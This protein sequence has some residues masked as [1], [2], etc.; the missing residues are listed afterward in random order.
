MYKTLLIHGERPFRLSDSHRY[1]WAFLQVLAWESS[2]MDHFNV[3]HSEKLLN[4]DVSHPRLNLDLPRLR[5]YLAINPKLIAE[6]TY[7]EVLLYKTVSEPGRYLIAGTPDFRPQRPKGAKEMEV[8]FDTLTL[9]GQEERGKKWKQRR[10]ASHSDCS[11]FLISIYF[12]LIFTLQHM[13]A[14]F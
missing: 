8:L 5:E 10:L 9:I 6:A 4:Q 7:W 14:S 12:W 2:S 13:L 3:A 1:H 11:I